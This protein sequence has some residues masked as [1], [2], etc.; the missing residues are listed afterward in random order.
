MSEGTQSASDTEPGS[1][2]RRCPLDGC[3]WQ[4]EVE[5]K[6]PHGKVAED[7]AERHAERHFD[8][9]HRGEAEI[10]VIL[11]REVSLH[12]EQE[13]QD[14]VDREHDQV[15][16]D[17]PVG[18]DL[19]CAYGEVVKEPDRPVDTDTEHERGGE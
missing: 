7:D 19:V 9:Q 2:V 8:R 4:V 3:G 6:H 16:D 17:V 5:K 11:R 13:L 10:K 14:V 1:A 12:P 18:Y 15:Q